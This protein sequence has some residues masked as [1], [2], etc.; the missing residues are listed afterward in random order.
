M[1]FQNVKDVHR[2]NVKGARKERFCWNI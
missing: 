1:R 2:R